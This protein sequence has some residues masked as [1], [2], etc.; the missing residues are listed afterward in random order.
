METQEFSEYRRELISLARPVLRAAP[1]C[2]VQSDSQVMAV[3]AALLLLDD[4]PQ[5]YPALVQGFEI[6]ARLGSC[7][8]P[9]LAD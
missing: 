1:G 5:I 4:Q 8:A 6:L 9:M 7:D 2:D 3:P